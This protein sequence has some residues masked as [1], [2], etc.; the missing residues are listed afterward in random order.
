MASFEA[1]PYEEEPCEEFSVWSSALHSA[2]TLGARVFVVCER[3]C[4]ALVFS[5]GRALCRTARACWLALSRHPLLVGSL[6]C[7]AFGSLYRE[8]L[9]PFL[10]ATRAR[11]QAFLSGLHEQDFPSW[12]Q[13]PQDPAEL[14][15]SDPLLVPI[16]TSSPSFTFQA[17]CVGL[18]VCALSRV[19][20]P[21]TRKISKKRDRD[22]FRT[23]VGHFTYANTRYFR[24]HVTGVVYKVEPTGCSVQDGPLISPKLTFYG[25]KPPSQRMSYGYSFTPL[26]SL[27]LAESFILHSPP[28]RPEPFGQINKTVVFIAVEVHGVSGVRDVPIGVGFRFENWIITN[29]HLF[30]GD[31]SFVGTNYHEIVLTTFQKDRNGKDVIKRVKV[32]RPEGISPSFGVGKKITGTWEDQ[33]AFKFPDSLFSQ[34]GLRPLTL[35][36]FVALGEGPIKVYG[37]SGDAQPE[38]LAATGAIKMDYDLYPFGSMSHTASTFPGWSGG[39][40]FL[41]PSIGEP[42]GLVRVVGVHAGGDPNNGR[43]IGISCLAVRDFL[44]H[45]VVRTHG[46]PEV[47]AQLLR[48]YQATLD[49]ESAENRKKQMAPR[50]G[51]DVDPTTVDAG[52]GVSMGTAQDY[53]KFEEY[54]DQD[55]NYDYEDHVQPKGKKKQNRNRHERDQD[56]TDSRLRQDAAHEARRKAVGNLDLDPEEHARGT[57]A[58]TRK[59]HSLVDAMTTSRNRAIFV[60]NRLVS[61]NWADLEDDDGP[62]PFWGV[63]RVSIVPETMTEESFQELLEQAKQNQSPSLL[64]AGA[65]DA[66]IDAAH[67]FRL[68]QLCVEK[69]DHPAFAE[70]VHRSPMGVAVDPR[71][72]KSLASSKEALS[73]ARF[74]KG[75]RLLRD[76]SYVFHMNYSW[77][78]TNPLNTPWIYILGTP[79]FELVLT[80]DGLGLEKISVPVSEI[81]ASDEQPVEDLGLSDSH[82]AMEVAKDF[83]MV[84]AET[85]RRLAYRRYRPRKPPG[86][87]KPRPRSS[88]PVLPSSHKQTAVRRRPRHDPRNVTP[89]TTPMGLAPPRGLGLPILPPRRSHFGAIFEDDVD[90]PYS[91]QRQRVIPFHTYGYCIADVAVKR[92]DHTAREYVPGNFPDS[93]HADVHGRVLIDTGEPNPTQYTVTDVTNSTLYHQRHIHVCSAC[94]GRY[95]HQHSGGLVRHGQCFGQCPYTNCRRHGD[96]A[97]RTLATCLSP[98]MPDHQLDEDRERRYGRDPRKLMINS[99]HGPRHWARSK[100]E[101][102]PYEPF[103]DKTRLTHSDRETIV[104]WLQNSNWE[105]LEACVGLNVKEILKLDA[106]ETFRL[107]LKSGKITWSDETEAIVQMLADKIDPTDD[108]HMYLLNKDGR[109]H[110]ERAGMCT[111]LPGKAPRTKPLHVSQKAAS[112]V[113][114]HGGSKCSDFASYVLPPNAPSDIIDSLRGQVGDVSPGTLDQAWRQPS[115]RKIWEEFLRTIPTSGNMTDESF[116]VQLNRIVGEM[117][118]DKSTGWSARFRPGLKDQW[119]TGEGLELLGYL[120]RARMLLRVAASSRIHHMSGREIVSLGL[121]DPKEIFVKDEAHSGRKAARRRWRLIWNVSIVD[122]AT[123]S[124]SNR[125]QNKKNIERFSSGAPSPALVGLGHDD[126]GVQRLGATFERMSQPQG[127]PR[128]FTVGS[129]M[130]SDINSPTFDRVPVTTTQW[131]CPKTVEPPPMAKKLYSSDASG[132]DLTVSRD[133]YYADAEARARTRSRRSLLDDILL[134]AVAAV[135]TAHVISVGGYLW[136]LLIYGA[137]ASGTPST[138]ATNTLIRLILLLWA[139][140]GDAAAAGDDALS[141]QKPCE[142]LLRSMGVVVKAG[143]ESVGLPCGPIDFT[144]HKFFKTESGWV[145]LYDNVTK[146]LAHLDLKYTATSATLSD[147]MAGMRFVLRNNPEADALFVSV[148]T[149]LFAIEVPSADPCLHGVSDLA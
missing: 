74:L 55:D 1:P 14:L 15:L 135:S 149:E 87:P 64:L 110:F 96:G 22:L 128:A 71:F 30:Y 7:V 92:W 133:A 104:D 5:S 148:A 21:L 111:T 146:M 63:H 35:K 132:W 84:E 31:A 62:D 10:D 102:K 147:A 45:L 98:E 145:A 138:S 81:E 25:K 69:V 40:I 94:G 143:S 54:D 108:A 83:I 76:H 51:K 33:I 27:P 93:V 97:R 88:S 137:M 89:Q 23:A 39:P 18:V 120:V 118:N 72:L 105:S 117:E 65:S 140:A 121:A 103:P 77:P 107:Y 123:E 41:M 85:R 130:M 75:M 86:L 59:E 106:M 126:A 36:N 37:L 73:T 79:S 67:L 129:Q 116:S 70:Y 115:H 136:E 19:L 8:E 56:L 53:S 42:A 134:F 2:R 90:D 17:G 58:L 80:P 50:Y 44:T 11:L 34:L 13:K 109:P 6:L 48:G 144:S 29:K 3:S 101:T 9:S 4:R 52:Y 122:A 32:D 124:M 82:P 66:R 91:E 119:T 49:A 20:S 38:P 100:G 60:N 68:A 28:A 57:D 26:D 46:P 113:L 95:A 112:L 24:D 43:N 142:E 139:G 12:F 47:P 141:T 99:C 114:K 61:G 16:A 78:Q 125:E 131:K 127:P